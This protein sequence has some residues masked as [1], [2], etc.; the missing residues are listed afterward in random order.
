LRCN[1]ICV[2]IAVDFGICSANLVWVYTCQ[3]FFPD[4]RT[5][6]FATVCHAT[7]PKSSQEV[8]ICR[9]SCRVLCEGRFKRHRS[10]KEGPG[11]I[12]VPR[13]VL[14]RAAAAFKKQAGDWIFFGS[15]VQLVISFATL[16]TDLWGWLG[17]RPLGGDNH[18]HE[19]IFT[20]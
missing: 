5:W 3:S 20:R 13:K 2:S 1:F 12:F 11:L 15:P 7:C 19:S 10:D 16:A 4:A 9:D 18:P 17:L 14:E 6:M 8:G